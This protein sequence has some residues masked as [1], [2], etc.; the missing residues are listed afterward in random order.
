MFLPSPRFLF[1]VATYGEY[2]W[3]SEEGFLI[4]TA[5]EGYVVGHLLLRFA[6]FSFL[7]PCEP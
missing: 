5:V 3:G 2:Y 7:L 6:D 4:S 1:A